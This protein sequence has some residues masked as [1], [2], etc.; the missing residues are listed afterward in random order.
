MHE[1]RRDSARH[2]PRDDRLLPCKLAELSARQVGARALGVPSL[3]RDT[4]SK[5]EPRHTVGLETMVALC[6]AAVGLI[7]T[8]YVF[9]PVL[10]SAWSVAPGSLGRI[11]AQI[12][13]AICFAMFAWWLFLGRIRL[14]RA[15]R[16]ID[17]YLADGRCA[18]CGYL[19]EDLS[20]AEDG[21]VVCPECNAA[22]RLDRIRAKDNSAA[23]PMG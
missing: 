23:D 10:A 18:S 3:A 21:C 4:V 9:L 5:D 22:W 15:D 1:K 6:G 20:P 11:A 7:L 13:I 8:K 12:V 14:A 2:G 16:I 17:I 19:L